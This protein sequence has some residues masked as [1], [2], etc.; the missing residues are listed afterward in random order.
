MH[1][2]RTHQTQQRGEN[3]LASRLADVIEIGRLNAVLQCLRRG[4]AWPMEQ[5]KVNVLEPKQ[6]E[7]LLNRRGRTLE[8]V[9][10][11]PV[12][13]LQ[14]RRLKWLVKRTTR[15]LG[16]DEDVSSFQTSAAMQ[17]ICAMLEAG[18]KLL[19]SPELPEHQHLYNDV[20]S[21][22]DQ[23]CENCGIDLG[24]YPRHLCF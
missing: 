3:V 23:L 8:R 20:K 16:R 24:D 1:A 6:L 21:E 10:A 7:I 2:P 19:E 11:A 13:R 5:H 18:E 9:R 22:I 14:R 17:I 4:R 15:Y 12:V